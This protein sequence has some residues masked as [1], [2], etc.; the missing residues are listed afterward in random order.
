YHGRDVDD[1]LQDL[2][3]FLHRFDVGQVGHGA[4]GVEVGQDDLLVRRGQDVGRLGHE[5]HATE[6]DV[7]RLRALLGQHG[8]AEGIP[9]GVGPAHDLVPLVVVAEDVDA[10]AEG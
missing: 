8:Q 1:A 5:V 6:D 4:A 2:P 7:V 3:G 10:A 9:A